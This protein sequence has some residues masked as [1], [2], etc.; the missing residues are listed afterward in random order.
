MERIPPFRTAVIESV[1]R[2]LG[3]TSQGLT[4]TEIHRLLA[5]ARIPDIDSSNTKWKRLFNAI[6]E[7]QS[8]KQI[9]NYLIHGGHPRYEPREVHER[10]RGLR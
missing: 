9:G 1:C 7:I 10:K 2:V 5:D 6:A 3:D 8:R 4:G